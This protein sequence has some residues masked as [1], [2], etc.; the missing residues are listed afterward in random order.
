LGATITAE[1]FG[2]AGGKSAFML[3]FGING[4]RYRV[5]WP[6]L[7]TRTG[8][9][10]AARIQA[11]TMLYHYCKGVCLR[12]VVCGAK[13]AFFSHLVLADGRMASQVATS[14]LEAMTPQLL[15]GPAQ[16]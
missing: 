9:V 15:L 8:S 12:A 7:P 13:D 2:E 5:V 16:P 6:V 14:E 10:A 11:A 4:D 1:G 3:A